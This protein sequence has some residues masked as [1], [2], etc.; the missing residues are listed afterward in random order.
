MGYVNVNPPGLGTYPSI[1]TLHPLRW[2]AFEECGV[3]QV[4]LSL[5]TTFG[6]CSTRLTTELGLCPMKNYMFVEE[7]A[8]H[9][10]QDAFCRMYS[11][12]AEPI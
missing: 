9:D 8:S 2:S 5:P 12:G 7:L 4:G 6:Y 3:R 10:Q 11:P 1:E